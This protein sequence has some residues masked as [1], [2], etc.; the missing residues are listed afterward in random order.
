KALLP[1]LL[2]GVGLG[3]KLN[4]AR[5]G[6]GAKLNLAGFGLSAKLKQPV[7]GL[8]LQ[9]DLSRVKPDLLRKDLLMELRLAH[10]KLGLLF[11]QELDR[12]L[13]VHHSYSIG[14]AGLRAGPGTRNA[15]AEA[16]D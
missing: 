5:F 1:L 3:A 16:A 10:F 13:H 14:R 11:Q 12:L 8:G 7:F 9:L 6:L 2:S 4:L 15:L